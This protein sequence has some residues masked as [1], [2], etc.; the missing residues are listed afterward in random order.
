MRCDVCLNDNLVEGHQHKSAER[1]GRIA[2]V[3]DVPML[4]CPACGMVWFAEDVSIALDAL[5]TA[6]LAHESLAVR[7]FAGAAPTP[8]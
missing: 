6:M 8:A 1:D 3:T 5:L 7:S 4:T 2:V